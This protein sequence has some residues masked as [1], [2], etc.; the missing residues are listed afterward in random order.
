MLIR[1][2]VTKFPA[3]L[4]A[5]FGALLIGLSPTAGVPLAP[6]AA[7]IMLTAGLAL[8]LPPTGMRPVRVVERR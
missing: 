4:A 8:L 6:E 2:R 1:T 7:M 3:G 5:G